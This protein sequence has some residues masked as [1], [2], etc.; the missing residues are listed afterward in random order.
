M[1]TSVF[2]EYLISLPYARAIQFS[3]GMNNL[4]ISYDLNTPGQKYDQVGEAI[5]KLGSWAKVQKSFWYV[6][7]SISRQEALRRVWAV[8]D[9]NDSLIVVDVTNKDAVW[10]NVSPEV[11]K[12][13]Q[14]HWT[15]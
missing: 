4:F 15:K 5:K 6:N 7:T 8:M 3:T 12:H 11:A 2:T 10:H 13:I 14:A 1:S 9:S